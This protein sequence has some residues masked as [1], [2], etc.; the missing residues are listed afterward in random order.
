MML[1]INPTH[2]LDEDW[3]ADVQGIRLWDQQVTWRDV[4]PERGVY[5]WDRLD[6]LVAKAH[7]KH[8]T[9]VIAGTPAWAAMHAQQGHFAPWI[10]PGSNSQ[11][12]DVDDFNEFVWHLATRYKDRI[13]VYEVWNEPQ[14]V[15]FWFPYNPA[16]LS[17]L[18]RMT[19][20]AHHTIHLCD[21]GAEV[22]A[23]SVLP[24][25]SSGGMKRARK[26]LAALKSRGWPVDGYTCHI[27]PEPGSNPMRWAW[28]LT[29]VMVAL[30]ALRAPRRKHLLVTETYIDLKGPY[31]G[32]AATRK[33]VTAIY[34]A[35]GKRQ[36][37]W[38]GWNRPDL[39]GSQLAPGTA[40]WEQIKESAR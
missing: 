6:A 15:E 29:Q 4:N 17:L 27:Y 2:G 18:A 21:P 35:R 36:V 40:A 19:Q 16:T 34:R 13:H 11:P 1:S 10:G 31:R 38:Y 24:R 26:Y 22:L 3:P 32:D 14:L 39:E 20:R 5:Q 33:C 23:A 9:Y 37:V 8:V 30:T 12:R 25:P 7:G 28:L